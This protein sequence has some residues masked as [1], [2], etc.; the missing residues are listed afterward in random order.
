M[1]RR[2]WSEWPKNRPTANRNYYVACQNFDDP[3]DLRH[4][5]AFFNGYSWEN[6][7]FSHYVVA[8]V[9]L[10]ENFKPMKNLVGKNDFTGQMIPA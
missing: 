5:L 1:T 3:T 6:I 2:T 9:A 8:W 10:P 7:P 4:C